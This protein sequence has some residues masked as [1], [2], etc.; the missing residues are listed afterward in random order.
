MADEEDEGDKLL[1]GLAFGNVGEDGKAD[2]D[3]IDD[4]AK[5]SFAGLKEL[6]A[7]LLGGFKKDGADDEEEE[8]EEEAEEP[9]QKRADAVDFAGETELIEDH[10]PPPV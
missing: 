8:D 4:D 1:L 9:A 10:G 5:A 7:V 3:Y 2:A 6:K